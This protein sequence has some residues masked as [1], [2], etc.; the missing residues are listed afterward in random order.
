M[1]DQGRKYLIEVC[2][3]IRKVF[4]L[5]DFPEDIDIILQQVKDINTLLN[6]KLKNSE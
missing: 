1:V 5:Q 3:Q 2:D 4:Q 6:E